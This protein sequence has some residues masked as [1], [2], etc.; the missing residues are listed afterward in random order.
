MLQ[1]GNDAAIALA[2]YYSGSVEAFSEAMNKEALN[3]GATQ[4]H[5]VN[6]SGYPN[7]DHYTTIYDMYFN[8]VDKCSI[9]N[10]YCATC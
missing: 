8:F 1:S 3:M 10:K 7:E 5:F 4:S 6:P 2:E 9:M